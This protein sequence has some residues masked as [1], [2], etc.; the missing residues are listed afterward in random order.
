M[1]FQMSY[2][3]TENVVQCERTNKLLPHS[4]LEDQRGLY[5][6]TNPP[7]HPST[8]P[9]PMFELAYNRGGGGVCCGNIGV[10]I[11]QIFG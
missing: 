8:H 1:N 7:I 10:F 3:N 11:N 2:K 4:V 6:P 5:F 9:P